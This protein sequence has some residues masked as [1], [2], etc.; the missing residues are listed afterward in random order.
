MEQEQR[1]QFSD[2][3][4]EV[5]AEIVRI[6]NAQADTQQDGVFYWSLSVKD[7]DYIEICISLSFI[8]EG[9]PLVEIYEVE[10]EDTS[11]SSINYDSIYTLIG[12]CYAKNCVIE[13]NYVEG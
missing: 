2:N 8:T 9:R 1:Y 7:I 4:M 6:T 11:M 13:S 5:Y 10:N 12:V 3:N